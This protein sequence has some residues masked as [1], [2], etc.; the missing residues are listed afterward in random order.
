MAIAIAGEGCLKEMGPH[1]GEIVKYV[2][3]DPSFPL[4]ATFIKAFGCFTSSC[5]FICVRFSYERLTFPRIILPF[6]K[7]SHPRVRWATCNAIGQMATDFSV[8]SHCYL[9]I[10]FFDFA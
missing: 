7:D 9:H 1:V 3:T 2:S 4:A 8:C 10:T 6:F 5:L